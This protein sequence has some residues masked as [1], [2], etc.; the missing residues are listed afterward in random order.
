MDQPT[1]TAIHRASSLAWINKKQTKIFKVFSLYHQS[2]HKIIKTYLILLWNAS[3]TCSF[4]FSTLHFP[5]SIIYFSR[6]KHFPFTS[7]SYD[8]ETGA[9]PGLWLVQ[10]SGK[11]RH[12]K[13]KIKN[14]VKDKRKSKINQ[15]STDFINW[16]EVQEKV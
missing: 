10:S 9:C 2:V 8:S 6:D 16:L 1:Y 15:V 4:Y 5:H 14:P 11:W 3:F 13:I 7:S 12:W